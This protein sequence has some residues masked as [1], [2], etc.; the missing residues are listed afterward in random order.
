MEQMIAV[1]QVS[2]GAQDRV[3]NG[4]RDENGGRTDR[5]TTQE[6]RIGERRGRSVAHT[7]DPNPPYPT[8]SGGL[9]YRIHS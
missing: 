3:E 5:C 7:D 1:R 8:A 4:R 9:S 6:A 2:E